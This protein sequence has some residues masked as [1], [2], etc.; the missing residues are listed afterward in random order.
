MVREDS[1]IAPSAASRIAD[2]AYLREFGRGMRR[3]FRLQPGNSL[4]ATANS[5][6]RV[7]VELQNDGYARDREWRRT[8]RFTAGEG[9]ACGFKTAANLAQARDRICSARECTTGIIC[10]CR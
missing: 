4:W 1:E 8:D 2:D 9:A 7:R 5:R 10:L 6:D 3:K